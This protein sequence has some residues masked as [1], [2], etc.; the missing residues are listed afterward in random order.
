MFL[1]STTILIVER[2]HGVN[3]FNKFRTNTTFSEDPG[4]T[5]NLGGSRLP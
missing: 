4:V 3:R 1:Y 5:L 2:L